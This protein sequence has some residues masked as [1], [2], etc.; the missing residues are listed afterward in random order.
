MYFFGGND[1]AAV[2]LRKVFKLIGANGL[3]LFG[4][5]LCALIPKY[6]AEFSVSAPQIQRISVSGKSFSH[7]TQIFYCI[8]YSCYNHRYEWGNIR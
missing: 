6:F 7:S 3:P 5:F 4:L 1:C 2:C 8:F